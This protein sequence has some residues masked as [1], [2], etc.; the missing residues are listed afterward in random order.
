M[1]YPIVFVFSAFVLVFRFFLIIIPQLPKK[2]TG[3]HLFSAFCFSSYF[4]LCCSDHIGQKNT[5]KEGAETTRKIKMSALAVV[6]CFRKVVGPYCVSCVQTVWSHLVHRCGH[7]VMN[8]LWV[9]GFAVAYISLSSGTFLPLLCPLS[10]FKKKCFRTVCLEGLSDFLRKSDDL[11]FYAGKS[12]SDSKKRVSGQIVT[13]L[14]NWTATERFSRPMTDDDSIPCL[15]EDEGEDLTER[16]RDPIFLTELCT[17]AV[18]TQF[19]KKAKPHGRANLQI[20]HNRKG[21]LQSK[22]DTHGD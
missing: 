18:R 9:Y 22:T 15:S 20:E 6:Y 8:N 2:A 3:V 5:R 7:G 19:T 1:N 11:P 17:V 21:A 12:E 16:G 4:L 14:K 10:P 13:S